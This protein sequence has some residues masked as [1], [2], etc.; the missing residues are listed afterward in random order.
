[1]ATS[2]IAALSNAS[3]PHSS[4]IRI[5][6]TNAEDIEEILQHRRLMFLDMGHPEAVLDVIVESCRPN[7]QRY[8]AEGSYRGWFAVTAEGRVAA[9][10]GLLITPLVSGPLAPENVNRAYLLNVYT[11]PEFRKRGLARELTQEAID[12]CRAEGFK[13]LW[14]H[15]S[16]YGRPIYESM[17]FEATNEMKLIID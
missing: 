5:R 8:L 4:G 13:V 9:G 6:E 7:I 16:K 1:M 2:R 3:G 10:V 11:Y 15:A 17:G 12:Y 14:L